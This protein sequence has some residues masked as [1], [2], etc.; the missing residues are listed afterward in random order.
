[1]RK[2]GRL[3]ASA[4]GAIA[5]GI[6]SHCA[7]AAEPLPIFDAHVHYSHD[8][9]EVLPPAKVLQ[10]IREAGVTRVLVSS[11]DDDG[12]QRLVNLAPD[13]FLPSLRPYRRR[14]DVSTWTR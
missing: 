2:P 3:A 1:M 9:W 12:Q 13:V 5:V 8:A 6:A 11:S 4:I 10:L 7:S 14:G